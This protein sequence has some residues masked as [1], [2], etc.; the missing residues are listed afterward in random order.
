[1]LEAD[2]AGLAPITPLLCHKVQPGFFM[3]V[4][5]R[6][7]ED[8]QTQGAG[9]TMHQTGRRLITRR[10]SCRSVVCPGLLLP[11]KPYSYEGPGLSGKPKINGALAAE[12]A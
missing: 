5:E 9:Y 11:Y 8:L 1:M 7:P 4:G 12:R 3:F 2:I 6:L 10:G